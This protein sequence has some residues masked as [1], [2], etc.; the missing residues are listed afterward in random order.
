MIHGLR[1][2]APLR[3]EAWM[4]DRAPPRTPSTPQ[5]P[6]SHLT[7]SKPL[8]FSLPPPALLTTPT[9]NAQ[10]LSSATITMRVA[11]LVLAFAAVFVLASP[12]ADKKRKKSKAAAPAA[13]AAPPADAASADDAGAV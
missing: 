5:Q 8:L 10:A 3:Q 9:V 7:S 2:N 11:L 4:L 13:D 6:F 12:E 1:A